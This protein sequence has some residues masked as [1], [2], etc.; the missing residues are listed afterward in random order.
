M[1]F[2]KINFFFHLIDISIFEV[3]LKATCWDAHRSC[4]EKVT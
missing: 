1:T 3:S 2:F 4:S